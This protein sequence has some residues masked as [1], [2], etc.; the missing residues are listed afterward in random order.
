MFECEQPATQDRSSKPLTLDRRAYVRLPCNQDAFCSTP[1]GFG[2]ERWKV[3]VRDASMGG[4]ALVVP[5]PVGCKTSLVISLQMFGNC[6]SRPMI[7]QVVRC[8]EQA[9][10]S[11]LLGCRF[12]RQLSDADLR[13]LIC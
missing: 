9:D 7:V 10:G 3:R 13:S 11:W 12:A 1:N 6:Y 8:E 4:L 5:A 2:Q